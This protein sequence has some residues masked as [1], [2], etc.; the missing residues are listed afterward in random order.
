MWMTK[1]K[2]LAAT[3]LTLS[4]VGVGAGVLAKGMLVAQTPAAP[5]AVSGEAAL[6]NAVKPNAPDEPPAAAGKQEPAR[7]P[8]QLARNQAESRL[9][10]KKLVVA[11]HNHH[12]TFNCLPAPAI[13]SDEGNEGPGTGGARL[14]PGAGR[15]PRPTGPTSIA[16]RLDVY[17]PSNPGRPSGPM[18][19]AP[20]GPAVAR[21][22]GQLAPSVVVNEGKALLS[23]RVAILPYL[24]ESETRLYNE[25]KLNEPWDSPHNKKLLARM[26]KIY[27]PPGMTTR[28]PY[29]T[30]YQVFVGPH[31]AFE[32]HQA[33]SLHDFQNGTSSVLLIVEGGCAV[34][35]TKPADLH[36]AVDEPIPELGGL[37]PEIFH[38]AFADGWVMPLSKKLDAETLRRLIMR[39]GGQPV[40]RNEFKVPVSRREAELKQQNERLKQQVERE[41]S[42]LPALQSEKE[43]LQEMAE[44]EGIELQ[45][46][47]TAR[48]EQL[49]R[50]AH[51]EAEQ[52]HQEI[53]RLKGALEKRPGERDKK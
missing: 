18:G 43:L 35:W 27:A 25:F 26:P 4:L 38:A 45:K 47:E 12:S 48:L 9:N 15:G 33:L 23:W 29:S 24:G 41:R 46:K 32:Q 51:E 28:E 30:Y 44:D 10:L 39:D 7:D 36:F 52:L 5:S 19:R 14:Y 20:G 17:G 16:G 13:Y 21:G 2:I 53:Q 40:D 34:P 37:F 1:L 50:Q 11:M 49:L 6:A 3:G 42:R 8:L 22:P 31:A